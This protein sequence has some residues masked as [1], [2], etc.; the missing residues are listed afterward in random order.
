M[1]GVDDDRVTDLDVRDAR[2]DLVHPA[3]VLMAGRVRELDVGP[4]GP[5]ALLDVQIGAAQAG[6][7]D[8]HDDV[9]GPR[10][11]RLVD[12]VELQGLVVLVQPRGLHAATSSWSGFP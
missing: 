3:G 1:K 10:G 11:L 4:G 5:L 12:R 9:E 7:A 6:R 8:A 2:A